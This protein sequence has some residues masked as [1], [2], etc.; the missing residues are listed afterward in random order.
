M[1]SNLSY[2]DLPE[3]SYTALNKVNGAKNLSPFRNYFTVAS[4]H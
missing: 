1:L 2:K 3:E 4:S